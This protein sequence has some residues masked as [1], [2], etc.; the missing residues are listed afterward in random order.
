MKPKCDWT[1]PLDYRTDYV[2]WLHD[3]NESTYA[4]IFGKCA[5]YLTRVILQDA[6]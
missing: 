4:H 1:Y 2:P 5:L 3:T 6:I